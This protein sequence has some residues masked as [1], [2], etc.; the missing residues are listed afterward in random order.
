MNGGI[1][2]KKFQKIKSYGYDKK[3]VIDFVNRGNL[4]KKNTRIA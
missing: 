3:R 1:I 2:V 4:F